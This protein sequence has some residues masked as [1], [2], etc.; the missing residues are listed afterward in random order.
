MGRKRDIRLDLIRTIAILS[1]ISV[2]FLLHSGYYT[3]LLL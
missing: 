3:T 1:V 2:H